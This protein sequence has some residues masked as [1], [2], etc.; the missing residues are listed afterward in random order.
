MRRKNT[1]LDFW[2]RVIIKSNDKCWIYQTTGKRKPIFQIEGQQK[3]VA[4][5]AYTFSHGRT[6]NYVLHICEGGHLCVNPNHLTIRGT[7]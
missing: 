7:R 1:E 4:H 3:S 5:W 2:K 6:R